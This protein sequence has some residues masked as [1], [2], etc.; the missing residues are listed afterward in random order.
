LYKYAS[1]MGAGMGAC[2]RKGRGWRDQEEMISAALLVVAAL[3]LTTTYGSSSKA[4]L[5]EEIEGVRA[6]A[7]GTIFAGAVT[8][9][10]DEDSVWAE[11]VLPSTSIAIGGKYRALVAPSSV[12]ESEKSMVLCLALKDEGSPNGIMWVDARLAAAWDDY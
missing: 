3:C 10:N 4:P 6:E 8:E 11:V 1:G 7:I 2:M 12:F 9:P 5:I